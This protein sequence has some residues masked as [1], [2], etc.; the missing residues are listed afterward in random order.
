[1][2]EPAIKPVRHG[3]L[4]LVENEAEELTTRAFNQFLATLNLSA[5][6]LSRFDDYANPIN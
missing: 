3:I 5:P 6:R 4:S 2:L 1:L